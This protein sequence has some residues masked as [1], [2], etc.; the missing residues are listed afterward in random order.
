MIV[1]PA[2][3]HGG[4]HRYRPRLGESLHPPVQVEPRSRNLAFGVNPTAGILHAVTD[5]LLVNI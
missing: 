1:D 2:G 5:R 4:F 3:E